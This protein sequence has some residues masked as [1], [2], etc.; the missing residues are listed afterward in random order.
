VAE[1]I[2]FGDQPVEAVVG[3]GRDMPIAIPDGETVAVAV[4]GVAEGLAGVIVGGRQAAVRPA[5]AA[6]RGTGRRRCS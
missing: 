1:C 4:V 2:G 3:E 6:R 5:S